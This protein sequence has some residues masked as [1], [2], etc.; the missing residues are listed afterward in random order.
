MIMNR[1]PAIPKAC[2]HAPAG[3]QDGMAR[4]EEPFFKGQ[5]IIGKSD[6][7]Q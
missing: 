3:F 2:P 6:V 1:D 7:N 5:V 4:M